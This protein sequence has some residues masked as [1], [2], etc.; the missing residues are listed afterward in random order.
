MDEWIS[1]T[2]LLGS[3]LNF[4]TDCI[5]GIESL[6]TT[7]FSK[8]PFLPKNCVNGVPLSHHQSEWHV[9]QETKKN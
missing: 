8:Q 3:A 2:L 9:V 1:V 5:L 4:A 6:N 7:A